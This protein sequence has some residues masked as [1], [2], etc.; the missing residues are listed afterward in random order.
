MEIYI[1]LH[2]FYKRN[3]NKLIVQNIIKVICLIRISLRNGAKIF[4]FYTIGHIEKMQTIFFD[5][6]NIV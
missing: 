1:L 2:E 4:S 5:E 6:A 3:N